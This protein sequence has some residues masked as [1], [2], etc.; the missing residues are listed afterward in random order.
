MLAE[1]ER[2]AYVR[3]FTTLLLDES[4]VRYGGLGCVMRAKSACGEVLAVKRLLPQTESSQETSH[5][6]SD[7]R[8]PG[9]LSKG[10]RTP[11]HGAFLERIS[12][13]VRMGIY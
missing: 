8:A 2:D 11:P 3:R 13:S 5:V 7:E 4:S 12:P 1:S 10:V 9:R 6:L